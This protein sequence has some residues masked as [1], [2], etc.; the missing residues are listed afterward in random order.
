MY[1]SLEELLASENT[2]PSQNNWLAST[3]LRVSEWFER[4]FPDAYA[5]AIV[6][7]AASL[8]PSDARFDGLASKH[9]QEA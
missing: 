9:L 5:L 6:A 3:G 1:C 7:S 2:S 4:W 8:P